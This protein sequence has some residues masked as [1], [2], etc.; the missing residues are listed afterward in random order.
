MT[1]ERG[2][3]QGR[4]GPASAVY[5]ITVRGVLGPDW[6]DWFDGLTVRAEP[7]G[8]TTL[9]GA[10]VDQAALHGLLVKV[11]DLGLPLLAVARVPADGPA[12]DKGGR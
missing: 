11:R 2:R 12:D 7:G 8:E 1:T 9:S 6:A 10:V 5:R 4:S 3:G